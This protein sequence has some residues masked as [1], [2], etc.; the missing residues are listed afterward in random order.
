M[1][2]ALYRSMTHLTYPD[3]S[4]SYC[5]SFQPIHA[6]EL[7]RDGHLACW[8]DDSGTEPFAVIEVP[9]GSQVTQ[10]EDGW[11]LQIPDRPH[12][13]DAED[14]YELATNRSLGLSVV[15]EPQPSG[16]RHFWGPD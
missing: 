11:Q 4:F 16:R 9:D 2:L 7:C 8:T 14:I 3:E 1:Q 5:Y 10:T 15:L 13:I 12:G 6:E